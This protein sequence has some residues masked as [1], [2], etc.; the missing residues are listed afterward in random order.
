MRNVTTKVDVFSFGIVMMELFTRIRLTGTIEH[1]EEHISLQEFV[2][3]SFQGGVDAVLSIVDDAIDIPTATQGGKQQN[4]CSSSSSSSPPLSFPSLSAYLKSHIPS[5]SLSSW[6]LTPATKTLN[7]L[8]LEI[9]NGESC[10][11]ASP[12]LTRTI[13]VAILHIKNPCS[14][15]LLESQQLLSDRTLRSRNHPFSEK[16]MPGELIE[17]AV[18]E[19]LGESVRVMVLMETYRV[20]VDEESVSYPGLPAR[21][22][23]GMYDLVHVKMKELPSLSKPFQEDI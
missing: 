5:D 16:M 3:K 4:L 6:G 9:T 20:E 18:K 12:S 10:L 23:T 19:E 2:E 22:K 13:N 11:L 8:Y 14:S 21:M 17:D 1:D 15:T 7:N